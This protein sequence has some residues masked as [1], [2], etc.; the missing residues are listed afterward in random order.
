MLIVIL[1]LLCFY[2]LSV[3]L[4]V[5]L[6]SLATVST[7]PANMSWANTQIHCADDDVCDGNTGDAGDVGD[8]VLIIIAW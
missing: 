4:I 8:C 2:F 6:S 1:G 3:L 7:T 5:S